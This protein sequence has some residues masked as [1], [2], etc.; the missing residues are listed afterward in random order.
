MPFQ[1][2]P[3]SLAMALFL[4]L[5]AAPALG[6]TA[7][8]GHRVAALP[9]ADAFEVV[10]ARAAGPR[11]YFCAAADYGRQVLGL[12]PTA[13][14]AVLRGPHAPQV[15]PG[16][17]AVSFSTQVP[18]DG[19]RPGQGNRYAVSISEPGYNMAVFDALA[20]CEVDIDEWPF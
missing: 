2:A 6:F 12:P 19:R 17:R 10:P 16:R 3:R 13:R 14:I 7:Q 11:D 5:L 15:L 4:A 20:F 18:P 1:H 8:N 9:Q